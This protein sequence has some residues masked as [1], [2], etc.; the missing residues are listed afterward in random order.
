MIEHIKILRGHPEGDAMVDATALVSLY[1]G[2]F[3][4][5][6]FYDA[7]QKRMLN[8]TSPLLRTQ[9]DLPEAV[10]KQASQSQSPLPPPAAAAPVAAPN[11]LAASPVAPVQVA[12]QGST[13]QASMMK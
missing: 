13:P 10:K 9:Q 8:G 4:F 6:A 12:R 3:G 7:A 2:P 11:G 1:N 5:A